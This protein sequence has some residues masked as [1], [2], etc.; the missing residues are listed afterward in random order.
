VVST[1]GV[2]DKERKRLISCTLSRV[3]ILCIC[4]DTELAEVLE[5]F[6]SPQMRAADSVGWGTVTGAILSPEKG[7]LSEHSD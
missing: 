6:L 5:S 1:L 3:L 4:V 2:D 7:A